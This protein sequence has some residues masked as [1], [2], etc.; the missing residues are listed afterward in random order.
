RKVLVI[1]AQQEPIQAEVEILHDNKTIGYTSTDENGWLSFEAQQ[2]QSLQLMINYDG[3]TTPFQLS[4][5]NIIDTIILNTKSTINAYD[6]VVITG[7]LRP[8]SKS[9]S[10]VNIEVYNHSFFLSNPEPS[11]LE[12]LGNIN[13][14]RPQNN[15]NVCNTSDI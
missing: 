3:M 13:G 11:L 15:C 7:T 5:H 14:I 9:Q 8:T 2:Q 12:S 1:D 6:E 10:P 4:A